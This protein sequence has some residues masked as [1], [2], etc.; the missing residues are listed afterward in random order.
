MRVAL[1]N[2][3]RVDI[4]ADRSAS[5]RSE[6]CGTLSHSSDSCSVARASAAPSRPI[7]RRGRRLLQGAK[8]SRRTFRATDTRSAQGGST[9]DRTR[10]GPQRRQCLHARTTNGNT[11]S[12][13]PTSSRMRPRRRHRNRMGS[14]TSSGSDSPCTS[15]SRDTMSWTRRRDYS[16]HLAKCPRRHLRSRLEDTWPFAKRMPPRLPNDPADGTPRRSA[17]ASRGKRLR[18]HRTRA[19]RGVKNP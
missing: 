3:I 11:P 18:S 13:T 10:A 7:L 19:G 5:A 1:S 12:R 17:T 6:M 2:R 8:H 9:R 15:T 16:R 4:G 14:S